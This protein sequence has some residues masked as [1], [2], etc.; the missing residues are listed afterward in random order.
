MTRIHEL[1]LTE[2]KA[3][4][5]LRATLSAFPASTFGTRLTKRRSRCGQFWEVAGTRFATA[6]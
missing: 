3:A 4:A 1:F 5:F 6:A 2:G